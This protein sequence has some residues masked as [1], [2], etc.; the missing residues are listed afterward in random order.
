MSKLENDDPITGRRVTAEDVARRAGVSRSAVSRTFTP[1]AHVAP[2]KRQLILSVADQLG[3]RPNALAAGLNS[4]SSNLVAIVTGNLSNHYDSVVTGQL[5]ER[6]NKIGKWAVVVGMTSENISA[7]D[8]LDVLA[9]P[10]DAMVVRAGSVDEETAAKCIKLNVP[11]VISGRILHMDGVDSL[12]CDNAAGT[13]LAVDALL[14]R[15]RRKIAYIGGGRQLA[16]EQERCAG[17]V[18]ALADAGVDP[19]AME[20]S[21]FSFQG[22]YDTAAR[23][24]AGSDR[25][26]ALFCCNDAMALGALNLVRDVLGLKVPEDVAIIG[27]DD[28]AMASWPC[29]NLTTIR[30][31]IDETVDEIMRLLESRLADPARPAEI[32][33]MHPRLIL[34]GTH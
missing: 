11:L 7:S 13:K 6:L 18:N 26:D 3:Y 32:V 12:G 8:I 23:L 10:L 27:F 30:N 9:Y 29:F 20:W 21:D 25:P 28:I 34:R 4:R 19:F 22:G 31:S 15:G 33:R 1:G 14:D 17:F 16:S 24:F 2:E 5:I